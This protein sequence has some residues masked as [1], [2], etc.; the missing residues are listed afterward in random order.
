MRTFEVAQAWSAVCEGPD[1]VPLES[2][3]QRFYV[4]ATLSGPK[5]TRELRFHVDTGGNTP[6]L[7]LSAPA[8]SDLGIE[9]VDQLPTS[10]KLGGKSFALPSGAGWVLGDGTAGQADY[11]RRKNFSAGQLGAGFLSRYLVCLDPLTKRLAL[12]D[13]ARVKIDPGSWPFTKLYVPELGANRARYPFVHVGLGDRGKI[14]AGYMLLLDSGASSSMLET[15]NLEV[16][17]GNLSSGYREGSF[18]DAD[19]LG[20]T[21][22][23]QVQRVP[24][25]RLHT[26]PS[27]REAGQLKVEVPVGFGDFVSRPTG[28]FQQMFGNWSP[29]GIQGAL[30]GDVLQRYRMLIDYREARLYVQPILG[31]KPPS[32]TR[33]GLSVAYPK[34][35]CPVVQRVGVSNVEAARLVKPGDTLLEVGSRDA[36]KLWHHEL[37]EALSGEVRE[38]RRLLLQRSGKRVE[39]NVPIVQLLR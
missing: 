16:V 37:M 32:W 30:G 6:G 25:L 35:E 10:L 11:R 15:R 28:T 9:R 7:M 31:S 19:M 13:P 29:I 33:V 23:E 3:G 20:G 18:G 17:R 24:E 14:F 4:M 36:C 27:V 39:V 2:A 8:A 38:T 5:G 12:A 1:A 21:L 22:K 26:L 34:G